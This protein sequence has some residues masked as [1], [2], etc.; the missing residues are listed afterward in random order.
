MKSE[1]RTF[2]WRS[3]AG[4]MVKSCAFISFYVAGYVTAH[5]GAEIQ[6][7][8]LERSVDALVAQVESYKD[9][10]RRIDDL[11]AQLEALKCSHEQLKESNRLLFERIEKVFP[12]SQ[13][14]QLH[15]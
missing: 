13:K 4:G 3:F 11:Q 12:K 9:S 6:I 10:I 5:V 14:E 8:N 1:Y 2:T 7:I 15:D